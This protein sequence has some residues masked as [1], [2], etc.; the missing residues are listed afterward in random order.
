M[1]API[2]PI[3]LSHKLAALKLIRKKL[4]NNGD[5]KLAPSYDSICNEIKH[6]EEEIGKQGR[7]HTGIM[8][9][10]QVVLNLI[11]SV[12]ATNMS[13]TRTTQ[14]LVALFK[15]NNF[16]FM[17]MEI[18][19]QLVLAVLLTMNILSFCKV[20][21]SG[22][23]NGYG[24]NCKFVGKMLLMLSIISG[25]CVRIFSIALYFSPALGLWNLLHHYQGTIS[26]QK[27]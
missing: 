4:L 17:N 22:F 5:M 6:M 7:I 25:S 21:F 15:T 18:P 23:I 19:S 3:I 24:S 8:A 10:I 20:Y 1:K 16:V 14:E 2:Q 27:E 13:L 12:Y 26:S 11:L 9:F